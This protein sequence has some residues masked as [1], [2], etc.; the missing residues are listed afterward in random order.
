[1]DVGLTLGVEEEY[2]VVDGE[3]LALRDDPA[4]PRLLREA[5]V[6]ANLQA[7]IATT[8]IETA[9]PVCT[10][11]AELREHLLAMR[12]AAAKV[13]ADLGAAILPAS[14]HPF[15][16]W[17]D[18]RLVPTPRYLGLFERWG[19]LALQQDICGCHVHVGVADLDTAVAV[20]DR[21]RP[22]LPVVAA[23]TGSSPFHGGIDTG[24]DSFRTQWYARWP[25]TGPAD[26]LGDAAGYQAVVDGL[27]A[28]GAIDDASHLYW[29]VR[30][31]TRYPT[32]EYR[33]GDVCTR[34]DD[35]VLHAA[36]VRSLTRVLAQRAAAGAP[37][38]AI[39]GEQ[40]R[41]ARWRAAR[42]GLTDHLYDAQA[43]RLVPA[44]QLVED[45]LTELRDDLEDRSEWDE[46]RA[47]ADAVLARGTSATLQ[48]SVFHR[49]GDVH[50]VA[51]ALVR[52]GNG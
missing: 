41:A 10:S 47:L 23:L 15:S 18:Q 52:E 13:T 5:P 29:D 50:E 31:S 4:L 8:Q 49:T 3:T 48:R 19:V 35:V 34:L 45:L 2:H 43:G 30:P 17:T 44:R 26:L 32:I 39:R 12:T 6:E 51:A 7:E 40:L 42:F 22:Y 37:P 46:V 25:L 1:M 38:L 33:I 28:T 24:Y 27:V 16:S 9:T 11:L 14:T 36:L 21:V 20:M